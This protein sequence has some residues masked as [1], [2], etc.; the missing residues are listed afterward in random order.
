VSTAPNALPVQ[1]EAEDYLWVV[2]AVEAE[3]QQ[4]RDGEAGAVEVKVWAE[5]RGAIESLMEVLKGHF[6]TW[7]PG[8]SMACWSCVSNTWPCSTFLVIK[9]GVPRVHT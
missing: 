8:G 2:A 4:A 5:A 1:P 3:L 9:Q 6:P 7:R